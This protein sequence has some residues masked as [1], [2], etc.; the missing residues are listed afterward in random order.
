MSVV[1][2]NARFSNELASPMRANS[3]LAGEER[4]ARLDDIAIAP[5]VKSVLV[6]DVGGTTVKN[7][8]DGPEQVSTQVS[9]RADD[10]AAADGLRVQDARDGWNYEAVSIGYPGPVSAGK[11]VSGPL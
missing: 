7:L 2:S 8:A 6:V 3:L 5:S 11:P 10:D 9:L 1:Q 4:T